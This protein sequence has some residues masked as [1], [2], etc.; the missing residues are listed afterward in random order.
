M[1]NTAKSTANVEKIVSTFGIVHSKLRKI[2]SRESFKTC[3]CNETNKQISVKF[4]NTQTYNNV[5]IVKK[6]NFY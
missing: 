6:C 1:L 3:V 5:S 2:R 4:S